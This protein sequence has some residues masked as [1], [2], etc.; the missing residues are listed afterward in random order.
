MLAPLNIPV[1]GVNQNLVYGYR[2]NHLPLNPYAFCR[3][4]IIFLLKTVI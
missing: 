3:I 1:T 2:F 4:D